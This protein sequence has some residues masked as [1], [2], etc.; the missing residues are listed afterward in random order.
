[1][2]ELRDP[3]P[4]SSDVTP[5][6]WRLRVLNGPAR[7]ATCEVKGRVSI[8]RASSSDLQLVEQEISR[9][10]ARIVED[11]H[12]DHVLEDLQSSNGTYVDGEA[13]TRHVLRP[14]TV[15][16]VVQTELVFEPTSAAEALVV[17]PPARIAD[18]RTMRN[19]AEHN[20]LVARSHAPTTPTGAAVPSWAITDRDG[21]ALIFER[22]DGGEYE[23]N[24]VD[25][26]IEYRMLR[27]Q[28]LRGGF[29]DP[30]QARRFAVLRARL[31]QPAVVSARAEQRTFRRF[32]CWLPAELRLASGEDHPCQVRDIGVDGAQIV[33][34]SHGLEPEAIVWLAIEVL[35]DGQ[36]RSLV[37]AARVAWIDD[38]YVGLAFAG[39][40]RRVEGRYAQRPGPVARDSVEDRAVAMRTPLRAAMRLVSLPAM[41]PTTRED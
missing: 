8:G 40:P 5:A 24:L 21:R 36:P 6:R 33:A 25:D 23:G 39:A 20:C 19:T 4:P 9:Q 7:G 41:P 30:A 17:P 38:E 26:V 32:G 13:I 22:P 29:S 31:V 37:L 11:E 3:V 35:E 1:M 2:A 18:I 12:G 14:H 15:F 16:T 10:H 34:V 28:H 27:A